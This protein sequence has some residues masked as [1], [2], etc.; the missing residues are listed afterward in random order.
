MQF[1]RNN[2]ARDNW[3]VNNLETERKYNISLFF[4]QYEKNILGDLI[5]H[6]DE[7]HFDNVFSGHPVKETRFVSH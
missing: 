4:L 7:I 3:V 1:R 2:T 6:G 5:I